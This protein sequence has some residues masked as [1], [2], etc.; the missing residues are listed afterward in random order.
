M[1]STLSSLPK[2][3]GEGILTNI[4]G[5]PSPK[6]SMISK[7]FQDFIVSVNQHKTK[8][9]QDLA[10]KKELAI[11]KQKFSQPDVTLGQMRDY[12]GRV[13]YCAILGYDVSFSYIHAVK[14][15]QQGTGFEKRM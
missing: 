15:A 7:G 2:F 6:K 12:L 8:H 14:L 3:I 11:L 13:I 1:E 4:I 5:S 9:E 10:I